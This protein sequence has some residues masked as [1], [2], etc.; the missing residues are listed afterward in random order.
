MGYIHQSAINQVGQLAGKPV[1]EFHVFYAFGVATAAV[2]D[3]HVHIV[4]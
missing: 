2:A 1:G 3:D 4:R